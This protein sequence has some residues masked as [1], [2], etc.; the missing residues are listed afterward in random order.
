VVFLEGAGVGM[1]I[2]WYVHG[3]QNGNPG[4]GLLLPYQILPLSGHH[5][6]KAPDSFDKRLKLPGPVT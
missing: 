2:A 6:K 5:I 4:K 1:F 3:P